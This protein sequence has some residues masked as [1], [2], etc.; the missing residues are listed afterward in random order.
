L[1][2]RIADLAPAL[3]ALF[4]TDAD[5]L[6]A[7]VGFV[8]RRRRLTP[9]AFAQTLTFGWMAR[10]DAPL[11]EFAA[12]LGV[13]PQAVDAR[14]AAA[15]EF[16][17]A[18]LRRAVAAVVGRPEAIPLLRSFR[19]VYAED[20]TDLGPGAGKALVRYELTGGAID[21][22]DVLPATAAEVPSSRALPPL[23]AGA[24]RLADRGFFDAGELRRLSA[25]GVRWVTRVPTAVTVRPVGQT[26]FTPLADWLAR[27]PGAAA[28][29]PAE[30][31]GSDPVGGRLVARRCPPGVAAERVRRAARTAARK[32]RRVSDRQRVLCGWV[33]LFTDLPA[34]RYGPAELD[35][36]YRC[37]WQVELLFKRFKSLGGVGASRGRRAARRR[38]EALVKLLAA[39][40]AEWAALLGG[41]PLG[42]VGPVARVRRAR[43]AA[44]RLGRAVAGGD[45][46]AVLA[47]LIAGFARL[48]HRRRR[49]SPSTRQLLFR[50]RVTA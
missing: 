10:P 14:L 7:Q 5:R 3:Q 46:A 19:G 15:A 16:V 21:V 50:P 27:Q 37:R 44:W 41:G 48:A 20:L 18:L 23:P 49:R 17:R 2:L 6:A 22:V 28:D 45:V 32:G 35:V 13:S 1:P 34:D 42:R 8:R 11:A 29:V 39:V 9:A 40:V 43:A 25:G 38:V 47:D 36:L 30:V 33:V 26:G 24:V 12:D 4:T 31:C